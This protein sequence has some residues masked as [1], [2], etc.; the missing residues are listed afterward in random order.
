M[1]KLVYVLTVETLVFGVLC[2]VLVAQRLTVFD[3]PAEHTWPV[4]ASSL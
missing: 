4:F 1:N 2:T 3:C